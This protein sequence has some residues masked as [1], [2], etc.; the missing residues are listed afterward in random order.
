MDKS[1]IDSGKGIPIPST[2]RPSEAVEKKEGVASFSDSQ[3]TVEERTSKPSDTKDAIKQSTLQNVTEW[4][5]LLNNAQTKV[6]VLK[7]GFKFAEKHLEEQENFSKAAIEMNLKLAKKDAEKS[8]YANMKLEDIQA[9]KDRRK[10][11]EQIDVE[12]KKA[13]KDLSSL[14]KVIKEGGKTVQFFEASIIQD[15]INNLENSIEL[16]QRAAETA[17]NSPE[18]IEARSKAIQT[19]Q[20]VQDAI[21]VVSKVVPTLDEINEGIKELENKINELKA[22]AQENKEVNQQQLAEDNANLLALQS[23]KARVEQNIPSSQGPIAEGVTENRPENLTVQKVVTESIETLENLQGKGILAELE[24]IIGNI[25]AS[26]KLLQKTISG[27]GETIQIS[28]GI[29]SENL[30]R[31][32]IEDE[33]K[34]K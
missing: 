28:I 8:K 7:H 20:Q 24:E 14:E 9:V 30:F 4:A 34:L 15:S 25:T 5:T 6:S 19:A 16:C 23:L 11:K 12:L 18:D 27:T 29:P 26:L 31:P 3:R 33:E 1:R 13:M 17:I 32:I 10:Q 22:G 2:V 21:S